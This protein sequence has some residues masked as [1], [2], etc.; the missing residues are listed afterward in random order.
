MMASGT[1]WIS[2]VAVIA[3]ATNVAR[4][5]GKTPEEVKAWLRQN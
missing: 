1:R 3:I 2:F 4:A 5:D